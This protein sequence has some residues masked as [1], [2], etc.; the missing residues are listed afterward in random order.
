MKNILTFLLLLLPLC[1][2]AQSNEADSLISSWRDMVSNYRN[3]KQYADA[4]K[5]QTLIV[6][7]REKI[8]GKKHADYLDA[9]NISKLCFCFRGRVPRLMCITTRASNSTKQNKHISQCRISRK[10]TR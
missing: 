8:N 2:F 3:K 5:Y 9:K 10:A 1:T 4:I 7:R 6:E